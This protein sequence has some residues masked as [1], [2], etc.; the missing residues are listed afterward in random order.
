MAFY[1]YTMVLQIV[2]VL[3]NTM[4]ITYWGVVTHEFLHALSQNS[5]AA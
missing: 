3:R 4:N 1:E 2:H 5:M